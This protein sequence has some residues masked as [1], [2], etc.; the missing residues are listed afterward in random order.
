MSLANDKATSQ[1]RAQE[2]VGGA[3][4]SLVI[5]SV[6]AGTGVATAVVAVVAFAEN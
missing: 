1:I 5:A 4:Q 3:N 2:L 6:L